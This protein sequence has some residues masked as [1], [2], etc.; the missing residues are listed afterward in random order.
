M[1][2]CLC[3]SLFIFWIHSSLQSRIPL[4]HKHERKWP[5]RQFCRSFLFQ[6]HLSPHS[7]SWSLFQFSKRKKLMGQVWIMCPSGLSLLWAGQ[8]MC[9]FPILRMRSG[10][11]NCEKQVWTGKLNWPLHLPYLT[12][13]PF[14]LILLSSHFI[15][16]YFHSR[17]LCSQDSLLL[18]L[19]S[20]W[21]FASN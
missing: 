21:I 17:M 11:A 18:S 4:L 13:F 2:S 8:I 15:L 14:M 9:P 10:R 19:K 16:L 3:F 20:L 7:I 6:H 1:V 12:Q 5:P